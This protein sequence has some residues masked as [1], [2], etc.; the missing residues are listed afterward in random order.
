MEARYCHFENLFLRYW[1]QKN[2]GQAICV[3]H[4]M[5]QP[6]A[7]VAFL[8]Q[9]SASCTPDQCSARKSTVVPHPDGY[10]YPRSLGIHIKPYRF[11][12]RVSKVGFERAQPVLEASLRAEELVLRLR[13]KLLAVPQKP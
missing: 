11:L 13:R 9:R 1:G 12:E 2:S 5:A 3:A 8:K 7:V 10:G 4:K 6:P